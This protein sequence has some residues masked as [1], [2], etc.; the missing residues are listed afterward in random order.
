MTRQLIISPEADADLISIYDHIA[1][2]SGT[3]RADRYF[4]RLFGF[5]ASLRDFP[6]Q[7]PRSHH[8]GRLM[9]FERRVSIAYHVTDEAVIIDRIRYGGRQR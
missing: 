5:I 6:E 8:G 4:E 9:S 2:E 7:A 1:A 3:N